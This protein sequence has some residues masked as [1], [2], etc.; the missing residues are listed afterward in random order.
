MDIF[1]NFADFSSYLQTKPFAFKRDCAISSKIQ[2]LYAANAI[3]W[4]I[5]F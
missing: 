2:M 1:R 3:F 4:P 5:S